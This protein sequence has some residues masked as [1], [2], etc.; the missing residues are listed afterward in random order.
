M[1]TNIT[2][3]TVIDFEV[4]S[5]GLYTIEITARCKKDNDLKVE[6]D[7]IRFR[8]IP[9][10]KNIQSYNISPSWNGTNLKGLN[11]TIYFILTLNKGNHA[12]TFTPKNNAVIESWKY[13]LLTDT[14]VINFANLPQ[15]EDGDRRPLYSFILVDTTLRS[16]TAD[17][18]VS[19]HK[20][21]GDDVKLII[22]N[23][24][25]QDTKSRFWKNWV[26]HGLPIQIFTGAKK[27]IKTFIKNLDSNRH[28]IEF[29]V[30]KTPTF[31][32]ITLNL[33]NYNPKR[34]PTV[35]DPEWTGKFSDDTDQMILARAIFGEAENQTKEVKI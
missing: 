3:Q 11:K 5:F 34:I 32:K 26:W 31:H 22:N 21:D 14:R 30:D 10:E 1:S 2:K 9:P 19:W 25:Q 8:E 7:D 24:I 15:V 23:E 6:I 20:F 18:S 12:L 13:T 28:Y 17:V 33:G 16:I 27:E 35:E 29:W 4:D